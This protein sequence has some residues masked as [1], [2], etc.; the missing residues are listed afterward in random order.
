MR[1]NRAGFTLIELMLAMTF[2]AI[3]MIAIAVSTIQV[4][5]LYSKGLAI[6]SINQAGRDLG[7]SIKRDA[8][9]VG[10]VQTPIVSPD[11]SGAGG[12][13][14]LCLGSVSYLWNKPEALQPTSSTA[15]TY[16]DIPT[17]KIVLTRV[18]DAGGNYCRLSGGVYPI[19]VAMSSATEMLPS[20]NGDLALHAMDL[21]RIPPLS[22]PA[23]PT[24]ALYDIRYTIGTNDSGTVNTSD[25]SC[26]PP[27]DA[28]QNFNFCAVN[29]FEMIVR[30]G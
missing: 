14:R 9:G 15:V 5:H 30:V 23:V 1:T 8:S 2:I 19:T 22:D 12:L 20:E 10:V 17:K 4:M 26:N 21:E 11:A 6:K 7:S 16:S 18:I 3:L 29:N 27:S 25:Y 13:G 24:E 28:N